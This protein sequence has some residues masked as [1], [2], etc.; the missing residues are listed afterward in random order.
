MLL[1]AAIVT[2]IGGLLIG[3]G[4]LVRLKELDLRAPAL[5]V[6]AATL[7]IVLG[8]AGA[9]GVRLAI[10]VGPPANIVVY[11]LVLL[12]L[13]T[14]RHLWAMRVVCGGVLLNFLVIFANGGSMPVDRSLAVRSGNAGLVRL[15]D[16]PSYVGHK[17]VTE[18]TKLRPL[19]DVLLLPM[20]FPRPRWWSPGSIGDI[21]ITIGTCWLI[22]SATGAFGL[23]TGAVKRPPIQQAPSGDDGP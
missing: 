22:L 10:Q 17:S 1:D 6:L 4:R 12:G 20:L 2:L 14:N 19:A 23:G 16:R 8:V 15:L 3:R 5:F 9:R 7:K 21:F 11:L 13:W 18:H